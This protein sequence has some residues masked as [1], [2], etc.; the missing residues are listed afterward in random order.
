MKTLIFP[1]EFSTN[2]GGVPQ[3]V[4]SL[5]EG[6][7]KSNVYKLI[8]LCP[9]NSEFSKREFPSNVIIITSEASEWIISKRKLFSTLK[10]SW[11]LYKKV[12]RHIGPDTFFVTNHVSA[13]FIVS[14]FPVLKIREIYVNRG[15]NFKGDG[16]GGIFIRNKIRFHKMYYT[17]A[18]S[19]HQ[20]NLLIRYGQPKERCSIIHNGLFI[21]TI[22]YDYV[23]LDPNY[24]RISTIGFVSS[25]K[26]QLCGVR[27]IKLLRDGG[28]N[29]YLYIYGDYNIDD[30]YKHEI[31]REI[32]KFGL[33]KYVK[34]KGFVV[35][36][37]IFQNTDICVSFSWSEGFGRTIVEG[38][39]RKKPVIAYRGAG[40]P[41]DITNNG[42]YGHL[43]DDNSPLAYYKA[44]MLLL[45]DSE[46]NKIN[47]LRSY[48][49][50]MNNFTVE[51]MVSKY[52]TLLDDL[53][54]R[55]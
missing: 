7:A 21:P 13:S 46:S 4:A 16:L 12:K 25:L 35:G 51:T 42:E 34:F 30:D 54:N 36:E 9:N 39:I 20:L 11:D 10:L 32:H 45:N 19:S 49:F 17:V 8:V 2:K 27:L 53:Y 22:K 50:A 33:D 44:I 43:V 1:V 5:V 24:L 47:V 29:A 15:G 41:V 26:N 14:L 28:I 55:I 23:R 48:E 18:T 37:S 3:S 6:I 38:M 52:L 40:G 31:D